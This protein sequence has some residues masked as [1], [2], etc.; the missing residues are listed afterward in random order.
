MQGMYVLVLKDVFYT[1][2]QGI[3]NKF[4]QWK[5]V[6]S[7]VG[8]GGRLDT[9]RD[10]EVIRMIRATRTVLHRSVKL[11]MICNYVQHSSGTYQFTRC[12]ASL[13]KVNKLK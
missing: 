12:K 5:G 13:N 8:R 4:V 3:L 11:K 2:A 9:V 1:E 6:A 7:C 10:Y